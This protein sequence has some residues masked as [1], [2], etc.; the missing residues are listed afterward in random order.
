M[1]SSEGLENIPNTIRN[2]SRSFSPIQ[3]PQGTERLTQLTQQ[4]NAEEMQS[5]QNGYILNIPIRGIFSGISDTIN[6][7]INDLFNGNFSTDIFTKDS[8]LMYIGILM[9]FTT[10]IVALIRMSESSEGHFHSS[11][12]SSGSGNSKVLP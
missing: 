4:A 1:S 2:E 3:E 9:L 10:I 8:R 11:E 5:S 7:I 12:G 6:G